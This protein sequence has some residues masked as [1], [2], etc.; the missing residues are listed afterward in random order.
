MWIR[1]EISHIFFA[2]SVFI[3][4]VI[5]RTSREH[6]F[7]VAVGTRHLQSTERSSVRTAVCL[8]GR[9]ILF[10]V[11]HLLL[12]QSIRPVLLPEASAQLLRKLC[13]LQTLEKGFRVESDVLRSV[14]SSLRGFRAANNTMSLSQLLMKVSVMLRWENMTDIRDSV[15]LGQFV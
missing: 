13:S 5:P 3:I 6:L 12:L 4:S 11:A 14:S 1:G 8:C 9:S 10:S 2:N 7:F 15:V